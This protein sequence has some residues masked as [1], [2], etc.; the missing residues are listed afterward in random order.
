M[1]AVNNVNQDDGIFEPEDGVERNVPSASGLDERQIHPD[2][3]AKLQALF[4][5]RQLA[6]GLAARLHAIPPDAP[7]RGSTQNW[8]HGVP[9]E[10]T[11]P[12]NLRLRLVPIPTKITVRRHSFPAP[13]IKL[14]KDLKAALNWPVL[15]RRLQVDDLTRPVQKALFEAIIRRYGAAAKEME[16]RAVFAHIPPEA[17]QSVKLGPQLEAAT[18]NWPAHLPVAKAQAGHYLVVLEQPD[19]KTR[20]VIFRLE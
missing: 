8:T 13:R 10:L 6:P 7:P 2:D 20:N 12:R 19:G 5:P 11:A 18:F 14:N 17:A 9:L 1:T 4:K 3:I 15:R 16:A